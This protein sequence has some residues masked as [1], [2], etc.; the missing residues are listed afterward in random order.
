MKN[1]IKFAALFLGICA[2]STNM[3]AQNTAKTTTPASDALSGF[4]YDF[5]KVIT[6]ITERIATPSKSNAD[7]QVF[8]DHKDFPKVSANKI[9]DLNAR[10]QIKT[11]M[12]KNP[13]LIINTLKHRKDIV[14]QY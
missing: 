11:W 10:D 6:L 1:Y 2:F 8:L 9:N 13:E 14:T 4:T 12:E 5:N 3:N 7:V